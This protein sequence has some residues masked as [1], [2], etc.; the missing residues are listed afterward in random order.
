MMFNAFSSSL[1]MVAL[2]SDA[3]SLQIT[4]QQQVNEAFGTA[5]ILTQPTAKDPLSYHGTFDSTDGHNTLH[6]FWVYPPGSPQP[7]SNKWD[8]LDAA[9]FCKN[10]L[11]QANL[12]GGLK[13]YV[14]QGHIAADAAADKAAADKTAS[15]KAAADKAAA[16]KTA[17]EKAAADKAAADKAAAEKAASDKATADKAAADKLVEEAKAAEERRASEAKAAE[18]R[19]ASEAKALEE[20]RIAD[21]Q[22]AE[23]KAISEQLAQASAK[24]WI[25]PTV[26]PKDSDCDQCDSNDLYEEVE[27]EIKKTVK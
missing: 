13:H 15:E 14:C 20:K 24:G 17:S 9:S 16:D 19:R 3:N 10:N 2:I 5:P 11:F 18:E 26:K 8:T 23:E 1:F 4:A 12:W 7:N 21:V 22:A 6:S 25:N 27:I